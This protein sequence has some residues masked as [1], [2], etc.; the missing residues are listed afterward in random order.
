MKISLILFFSVTINLVFVQFSGNLYAQGAS[1]IDRM[2][3]K[4]NSVIECKVIEILTETIKY[5]KAENLDGPIYQIS[6]G[7]ILL[8]IYANG[9]SEMISP[10]SEIPK[11]KPVNTVVIPNTNSQ[12]ANN[13]IASLDTNKLQ[14]NNGKRSLVGFSFAIP[15]LSFGLNYNFR[16]RKDGNVGINV[17]VESD[18]L[19]GLIGIDRKVGA[20]EQ[21]DGISITRYTGNTVTQFNSL[22]IGLSYNI[23][24]NSILFLGG[25]YIIRTKYNEYYINNKSNFWDYTTSLNFEGYAGYLRKVGKFYIGGAYHTAPSRLQLHFIF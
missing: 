14:S 10:L 3:K 7:E 23:N 24:K 4:D 6:K 17:H 16:F 25:G 12:V 1:K 19:P 18:Y 21:I 8:V 11:P 5:K 2:Y 9:I 15:T 13:N 20:T 22:A